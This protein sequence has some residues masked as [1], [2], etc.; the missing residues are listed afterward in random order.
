MTKCSNYVC[1]NEVITGFKTEKFCRSCIHSD[2][3][4]IIC[5]SICK[6]LFTFSGKGI[7][8]NCCGNACKKLQVNKDR[9]KRRDMK[10]SLIKKK[11]PTC[12]KQFTK[13]YSENYSTKYCS[14]KC[15][16]YKGKEK[17]RNLNKGF[18]KAKNNMS[19][20]VYLT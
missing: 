17:V 13:G 9:K 1:L 20:H 11:C 15:K 16:S 4:I 3:P 2:S 12:K 18:T 8:P 6:N 5:C 19:L 14:L 7:M 10:K